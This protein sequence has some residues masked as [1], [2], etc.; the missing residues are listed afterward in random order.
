MPKCNICMDTNKR[1]G[2]VCVGSKCSLRACSACRNQ[3]REAQKA[4][5]TRKGCPQCS[6]NT[7]NNVKKKKLQKA[8]LP[9]LNAWYKLETRYDAGK[10]DVISAKIASQVAKQR[11]KQARNGSDTT[12]LQNNANNK[13]RIYQNI[14]N[15][16]NNL[17][18][19]GEIAYNKW[20]NAKNEYEK[21]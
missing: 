18:A 20:K 21:F 7:L 11:L 6:R 15:K 1:T 12:R 9:L 14:K 4:G 3:T 17:E 8:V 2:P 13:Q 19:K 16:M 5:T 10:W